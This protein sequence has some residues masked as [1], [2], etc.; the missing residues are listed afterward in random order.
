M[1]R[2]GV[3][4]D[5]KGRKGK[6]GGR[7]CLVRSN[8]DRDEGG[9]FHHTGKMCDKWGAGP[10]C[11][12]KGE[13]MEHSVQARECT[14]KKVRRVCLVTASMSIRIDLSDMF[15]SGRRRIKDKRRVAPRTAIKKRHLTYWMQVGT[16]LG[17]DWATTNGKARRK[18]V[19]TTDKP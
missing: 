15:H 18:E 6:F 11:A 1:Q 13:G 4:R 19:F 10:Q 12:T 7:S 9:N 16:S 8:E 3:E 5:W 2:E 14:K 17:R